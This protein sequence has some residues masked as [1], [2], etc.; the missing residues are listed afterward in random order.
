[1]RPLSSRIKP[2]S[3]EF[4]TNHTKMAALVAELRERI[5]R[6]REGGGARYLERHREQGK[7]PV[8]ERIDHLRRDLE[9]AVA[10][11]SRTLANQEPSTAWDWAGTLSD[12]NKQQDALENAGRQWLRVDET[13]ARAAI[14]RSTL[15]P[16][17][18][19]RLL[20]GGG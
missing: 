11:F 13:A 9:D 1:M 10:A 3:P 5:A 12:P 20:K 6:A 2:D 14:E 4:T 17:L 8:R 19:E 15:P 16:D 18:K 7:L